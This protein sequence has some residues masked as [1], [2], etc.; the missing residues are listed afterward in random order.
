MPQ[1]WSFRL[2]CN[3]LYPAVSGYSSSKICHHKKALSISDL[4]S[5][6]CIRDTPLMFHYT[7]L[8]SYEHMCRY[9]EQPSVF[10]SSSVS[11]T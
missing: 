4:G 3:T 8:S 9:C 6:E 11:T 1:H 10:Q 5:R 2:P 7:A